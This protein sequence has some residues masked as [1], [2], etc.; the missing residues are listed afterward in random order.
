VGVTRRDEAI[1]Q[2]L[3][4]L[5]T[6]SLYS[7]VQKSSHIGVTVASET[8]ITASGFKAKCLNL[9]DQLTSRKLTRLRHQTR[10]NRC[11]CHTPRRSG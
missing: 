3:W 5:F 11:D 2:D 6:I 1:S 10:P 7:H 4:M 9:L 8:T